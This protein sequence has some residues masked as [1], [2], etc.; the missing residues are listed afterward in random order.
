VTDDGVRLEGWA[1][2]VEDQADRVEF[3]I[4]DTVVAAT[5]EFGPRADVAKFIDHP[6]ALRSGWELLVPHAAI[7][8]FRYQVATISVWS[9]EGAERILFLGTLE[10]R[11]GQTAREIANA[12]QHRVE[13]QS[14]ELATLRHDLGVEAHR[15]TELEA[16][17]AAMRA[18]AFWKAREKWFVLKRALRLTDEL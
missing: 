17:V 16:Q 1:T 7:R 3:R 4:E 18:S 5:R 2:G 11:D 13:L 12:L 14:N 15:R 8:S 10:S 6:A 9:R